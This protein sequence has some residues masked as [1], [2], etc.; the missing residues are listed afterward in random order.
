MRIH[1]RLII[2]TCILVLIAIILF[3]IFIRFEFKQSAVLFQDQ[4]KST[5]NTF[6]KILEL[7]SKSL[8]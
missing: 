5:E 7:K 3:S 8:E 6:D 2:Q 1:V 4:R